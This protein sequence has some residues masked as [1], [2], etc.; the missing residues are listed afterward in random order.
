MVYFIFKTFV[1]LHFHL[2][3]S[4]ALLKGYAFVFKLLILEVTRL[5]SSIQSPLNYSEISKF[6]WHKSQ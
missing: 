2:L 6:E 5:N 1:Q 3:S 4:Y